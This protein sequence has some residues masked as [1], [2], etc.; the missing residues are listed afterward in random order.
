M[1]YCAL[2]DAKKPDDCFWYR[3]FKRLGPICALCFVKWR[4]VKMQETE[5]GVHNTSVLGRRAVDQPV[6]P[7]QVQQLNNSKQQTKPHYTPSERMI[8]AFRRARLPVNPTW[9]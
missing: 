3:N 6:E 1:R 7:W 9:I 4:V 5:R 8:E 2:C